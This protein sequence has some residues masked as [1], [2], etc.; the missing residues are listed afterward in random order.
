MF[1]FDGLD[2]SIELMLV[3]CVLVKLGENLAHVIHEQL[4]Q[5]F[6]RLEHEAEELAVVVVNYVRKL[7]LEW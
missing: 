5:L 6:I 2:G 7:F 1:A 4:W 3:F